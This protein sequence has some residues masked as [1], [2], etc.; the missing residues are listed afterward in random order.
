MA[1]TDGEADGIGGDS[2][3]IVKN[4][5]AVAGVM[6]GAF[7][8]AR[9]H[10]KLGVLLA[11]C[12][13]AILG[14][15]FA[16]TP[17]SGQAGNERIAVVEMEMLRSPS[18]TEMVPVR[19]DVVSQ[20]AIEADLVVRVLDTDTTWRFP[21]ALAANSEISQLVAVPVGNFLGRIEASLVADGEE[22]ADDD[23][24]GDSQFAEAVGVLGL[25]APDE[26]QLA[27]D[28]GPA[29]AI[30][31]NDLTIL[32]ALDTVVT[33]P[34]GLST[35]TDVE[36]TQLFGWLATGGQI[37]VSD[38]PGSI[39]DVLPE[40]WRA[41][42]DVVSAEA[43]II[44]YASN[45]WE[46]GVA[47][48][49]GTVTDL[50]AFD[51]FDGSPRE[52]INDAGFRVPGIGI[53]ALILLGYL[54]IAGP[55]V[56]VVLNSSNRQRLTWVVLPA[57]ALIFTIGVFGAGRVFNA[58]RSDSFATIAEYHAA[59]TT[60]RDAFL[61]SSSGNQTIDLP[62]GWQ[63]LSNAAHPGFDFNETNAP[64]VLR[65]SRTSTDVAFGIESG[66]A[67]TGLITG[68]EATTEAPI[69]IED[70]VMSDGTVTGSVRNA[71][72][73]E[74]ANVA[75][76][77]GDLKVDVGAIGDGA[78]DDF[79]LSIDRNFG[80][81]APE[82]AD[83]DVDPRRQN[84]FGGPFDGNDELS[85]VND[86]P[87]NGQAWL[88]F[89]SRRTATSA[90]EG[91][92]TVVGWTR[93]LDLSVV[94]GRGRTAVVVREQLPDGDGPLAPGAVRRVIFEGGSF[95]ERFGFDGP[96]DFGRAA[97]VQFIAPVGADTGELALRVPRE[98]RSVE[99]FVPAD[100][101]RAFDL[102]ELDA[103]SLLVPADAWTAGVL[104]VR[105]D[106]GEFFNDFVIP[107]LEVVS[108]RTT[109]LPFVAAGEVPKRNVNGGD[110]EE[111]FFG[112]AGLGAEFGPFTPEPG[113]E[114]GIE[115]EL[116][117]TFDIVTLE[118]IEG[119]QLEIE[120]RRFDP[121]LDPYLVLL[122]PDGDM[123]ASD[124]DGAGDLNS[125]IRIE[126]AETGQYTI[127]ARPL[128]GFA[129]GG[130]YELTWVVEREGES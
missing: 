71:S 81:L 70:L 21:L 120:M 86:G 31:L 112:E 128:S 8:G 46:T 105:Y 23:L 37:V 53:I 113:I 27:F 32:G 116:F 74:L 13:L 10:K 42:R 43:G 6:V 118:L 92:V 91:F 38:D 50:F 85:G 33:S 11:V 109:S 119:D 96:A 115:S 3:T 4:Y 104:T 67:A 25:E 111:E 57:V 129:G 7:G 107:E 97:S 12:A 87:S 117:G 77:V 51:F 99:V 98:V 5:E 126:A 101:W 76:L 127:E 68:T 2:G 59:G 47:P 89:R 60:V 9:V 35:L 62:Q 83:W 34:A 72:G 56:F 17:V 125:R 121:G 29:S 52:L 124:D 40:A 94:D 22:L 28:G 66:S 108:E 93:E 103:T 1:H 26:L 114:D 122:G 54:L 73:V 82:L 44:R 39:D 20:R 90:P 69:V 36:R 79:E 78:A 110:F 95:N 48:S 84:F 100:G 18:G 49:P 19:I 14:S 45:D 24:N 61:I 41:N 55:I 16:S 75:V 130:F 30:E 123:V 63:L 80:Q 65:T 15:V 106:V 102:N 64:V 58:G 88:N